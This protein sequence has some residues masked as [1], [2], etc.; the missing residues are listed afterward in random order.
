LKNSKLAAGQVLASNWLA[1]YLLFGL[2]VY[3]TTAARLYM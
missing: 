3:H 2:M 1:S